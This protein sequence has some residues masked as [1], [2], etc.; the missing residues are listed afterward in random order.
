MN[1]KPY[2]II[3]Y[4]ADID[5]TYKSLSVA[6]SGEF[7]LD[8][9]YYTNSDNI[10]HKLHTKPLSSFCSKVFMGPIFK[11]DE[12]KDDKYGTR[13]LASNEIVSFE[14]SDNYITKE[15]A[16]KYNLIAKK[17]MI[18]VTGYGTIGSLR[19]VDDILEG[20]AIA[21]NVTRIIPNEK[22]GYI[23]CFLSSPIGNKLLNDYASGS[24]IRFIQAPQIAKIPVPVLD[25]SI[26]ECINQQYLTAVT[27]REQSYELLQKAQQLLLQ[28]NNLPPLSTI[29]PETLDADGEVEI[30]MTGLNEFTQ[31]YRL[32]AHFYNPIAKVIVKNIITNCTNYDNLYD[33]ADCSFR[34]SR[35]TRN[36]VD[37]ENG[38][39][40]LSGKN[41]IQIRPDFKYISTSETANI[42]DM[43]L[44][45]GQILI[46]RSG[47]LGRTI[48]IYKNYE[49]FA[50]SE[51]LIRVKPDSEIIDSGYLYAFL[52]SDYGY[53]QLLRYKHGSVIDEITEDQ[54]SQSVIPLPTKGQQKEIGDLVRKAYELRAEAIKLEDEAQELL[55]QALTKA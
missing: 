50:A 48:L 31:D 42:S 26:I 32:D 1:T 8:S 23:A 22:L 5:I 36:Y 34:G 3:N 40:F 44:T 10:I 47:T 35:S 45:E 41:I 43:L 9:G 16:I 28:Y 29:T 11:R 12:V 14:K 39:A 46:S 20:C 4:F 19:I 25:E 6:M 2:T 18:L 53:H 38:L 54:I 51:H 17:G 27:C 15:Q 7:R 37:K 52:S 55:T 30:R 13:F 33:I 21:D 24:A 49:G